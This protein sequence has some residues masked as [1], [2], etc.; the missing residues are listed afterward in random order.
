MSNAN[1]QQ[2]E[3]NKIDAFVNISVRQTNETINKSLTIIINIV[4]LYFREEIYLLK[5]KKSNIRY[6]IH[7]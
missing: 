2:P 3:Q 5:K 7:V 6:S 1:H 4:V